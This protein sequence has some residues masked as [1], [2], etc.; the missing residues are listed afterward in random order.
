MANTGNSKGPL[1]GLVGFIWLLIFIVFLVK[2]CV[3]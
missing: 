2:A 3:G 1:S